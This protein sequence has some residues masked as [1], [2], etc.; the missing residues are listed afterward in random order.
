M[1]FVFINK[2]A[3][4]LNIKLQKATKREMEEKRAMLKSLIL[5][6]LLSSFTFEMVA[7]ESYCHAQRRILI[8]ACTSSILRSPTVQCC[9]R[10]RRTPMWCVCSIITPQL[11]ATI[12][13]D[14]LNYAVGVIRQCGR[15]IA[16]GTK[17]GSKCIYQLIIIS[18]NIDNLGLHFLIIFSEKLKNI[19]FEKKKGGSFGI[20]FNVTKRIN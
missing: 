11:A 20:L 17:C 4:F 3:Y 18:N 15:P 9:L 19:S 12:N 16:R 5:L 6:M 2:D 14:K 13:A 7:A 8:K 10:I 1:K